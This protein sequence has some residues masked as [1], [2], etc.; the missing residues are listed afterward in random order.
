MAGQPADHLQAAPPFSKA[1]LD[2]FEPL[3]EKQLWKR[4]K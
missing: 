1:E 3:K 2:F 4:K